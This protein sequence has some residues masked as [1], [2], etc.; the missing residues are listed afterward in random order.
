[1]VENSFPWDSIILN[2]HAR[3]K[4]PFMILLVAAVV[5]NG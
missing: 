3:E 4:M 5:N 2:S 1:M